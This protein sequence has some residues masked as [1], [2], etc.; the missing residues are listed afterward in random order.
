MLTLADLGILR[1]V[2]VDGARVV[3]SVTPTYS[4]CPAIAE[5][6]ADLASRLAAA[7]FA[8]V[9]VRTVLDPPWT[10]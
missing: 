7:G 9:E 8:D 1:D 3:V 4:G 10:Q 2:T 6:R 5:I